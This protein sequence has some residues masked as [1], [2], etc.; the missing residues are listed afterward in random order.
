MDIKP[1]FLSFFLLPG[2]VPAMAEGDPQLTD[3]IAKAPIHVLGDLL[4]AAIHEAVSDPFAKQP[5][6]V[7][8]TADNPFQVSFEIMMPAYPAV[9]MSLLVSEREFV[10]KTIDRVFELAKA[11]E[12]PGG[13]GFDSNFPNGFDCVADIGGNL[14]S[15]RF[16]SAGVQF[17]ATSIT[18]QGQLDYARLK[19]L[20]LTLPAETYEAIFGHAHQAP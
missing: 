13:Q 5:G 11:G 8:N 2:G 16:G 10:T 14:I 12:A 15:C 9:I 7:R 3:V 18:E 17:S 20:F 6:D 1:L 4:P 19:A